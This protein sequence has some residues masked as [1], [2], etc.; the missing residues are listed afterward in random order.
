MSVIKKQLGFKKLALR[1]KGKKAEDMSPIVMALES[2]VNAPK[3]TRMKKI[4]KK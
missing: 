2:A 3:K 1:N 4:K